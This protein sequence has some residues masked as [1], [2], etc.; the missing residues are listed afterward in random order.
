MNRKDGIQFLKS[1]V[2]LFVGDKGITLEPDTP[3][4]T[5]I[6]NSSVSCACSCHFIG[7]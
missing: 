2:P 6:L 4:I 1:E 5:Y 7:P 3:K